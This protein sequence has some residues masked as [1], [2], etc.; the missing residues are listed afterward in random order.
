MLPS[1]LASVALV[2]YSYMP[3]P[4]AHRHEL[5]VLSRRIKAPIVA[6]ETE[7]VV[8][9]EVLNPLPSLEPREVINAVNAALHRS[10]WDTPTPFY[11]FEVASMGNQRAVLAAS[12]DCY[13]SLPL[14]AASHAA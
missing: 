9:L 10:N 11:G 3:A 14:L 2:A 12:T 4:L 6:S 5:R 7:K 1:A 8:P 13:R